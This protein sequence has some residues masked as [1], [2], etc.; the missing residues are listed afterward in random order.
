[1]FKIIKQIKLNELNDIFYLDP[2]ILILIQEAYKEMER[3]P[4]LQDLE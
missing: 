4:R 3:E 1:M 2:N